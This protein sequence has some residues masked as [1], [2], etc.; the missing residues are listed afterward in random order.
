MVRNQRRVQ[1]T[2]NFVVFAKNLLVEEE[3]G[4]DGQSILNR[5][6]DYLSGS[7]HYIPSRRHL[8][9]AL[10]REPEIYARVLNLPSGVHR[11][12]YSMNPIPTPVWGLEQNKCSERRYKRAE[13][14][15]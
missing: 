9:T 13:N 5:Y 4:K 8:L 2:N 12:V 7:R 14:E 3:S 11:T 10:R 15:S 6:F 1:M